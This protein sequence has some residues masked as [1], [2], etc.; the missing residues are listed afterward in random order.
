[1]AKRKQANAKHAEL[2]PAALK[3]LLDCPPPSALDQLY[4]LVHRLIGIEEHRLEIELHQL[5]EGKT[6]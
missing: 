6:K 4:T 1:M 3:A 2:K 5:L